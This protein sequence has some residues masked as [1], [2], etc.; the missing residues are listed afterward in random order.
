MDLFDI[1]VVPLDT[2]GGSYLRFAA[3]HRPADLDRL[4]DLGD[5]LAIA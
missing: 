2:S 1:A 5:K 4:A 3:L